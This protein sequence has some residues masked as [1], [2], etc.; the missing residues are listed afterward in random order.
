MLKW[1]AKHHP[2]HV[3][4]VDLERGDSYEGSHTHEDQVTLEVMREHQRRHGDDAWGSVRG[5]KYT[6]LYMNKPWEL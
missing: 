1:T 2:V 6:D 4:R 5:G 3:V